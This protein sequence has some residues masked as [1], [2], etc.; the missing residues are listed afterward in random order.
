MSKTKTKLVDLSDKKECKKVLGD[1]LK[2]NSDFSFVAVTGAGI[3]APT[4]M[5]LHRGD[6][7]YDKAVRDV[8]GKDS[9]RLFYAQ[10]FQKE[11]PD[12]YNYI[13]GYIGNFG[14]KCPLTY[15]H[16]YIALL[17][18][19][20]RGFQV[21]LNIDNMEFNAMRRVKNY[22]LHDV[23]QAHGT[24]APITR[25]NERV[26]S[27]LSN[28]FNDGEITDQGM[29]N[30]QKENL[31]EYK[32]WL[33]Y[34]V[35]CPRKE[36]MPKKPG[37]LLSGGATAQDGMD[38]FEK[39]VKQSTKKWFLLLV[40]GTTGGTRDAVTIILEFSKLADYVVYIDP[41]AD[42]PNVLSSK[43]NFH[44]HFKGKADTFFMLLAEL[45]GDSLDM[46]EILVKDY[47]ES[48][49]GR[50]L[51][52]FDEVLKNCKADFEERKKNSR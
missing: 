30:V 52:S 19:K 42:V 39:T 47:K 46:K 37:I 4:G 9:G 24:V 10:E 41:V 21:T 44:Y 26:V 15:T 18:K 48:C 12:C 45:L 43:I 20:Y 32:N 34:I 38:F 3:S 31:S 27:L 28:R 49:D 11:N 1:I 36:K 7:N 2:Q 50:I 29:E 51:Q 16:L 6:G 5:L 33:E 23:C 14:A 17:L 13:M 22:N 40:V 25:Y 8:F 35:P